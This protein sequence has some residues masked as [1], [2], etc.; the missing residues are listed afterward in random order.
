MSQCLQAKP[1]HLKDI[2]RGRNSKLIP[3]RLPHGGA[4]ARRRVE[5]V[6][7]DVSVVARC[8][9]GRV[10]ALSKGAVCRAES[11]RRPPARRSFR[12]AVKRNCPPISGPGRRA[13]EP[14]HAGGPIGSWTAVTSKVSSHFYELAQQIAFLFGK[15]VWLLSPF[16]KNNKRPLTSI[17]RPVILC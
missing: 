9:V 8:R 4:K 10:T 14:S 12:Y 1:A 2:A 6:C 17:Q 11:P 7:T 15:V 5:R 3:T 16:P 13:T